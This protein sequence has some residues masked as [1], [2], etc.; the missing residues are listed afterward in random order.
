MKLVLPFFLSLIWIF[1]QCQDIQHKAISVGS[2]TNVSIINFTFRIAEIPYIEINKTKSSWG[3]GPVFQFG[4]NSGISKLFTPRLTGLMLSYRY[5]PNQASKRFAFHFSNDIFIQRIG[6]YW[7]ANAYDIDQNRYATFRYRN[8]EYLL[9]HFMGY[10]F[11][12]K[13]GNHFSL[14]KG[15]GLGYY[16]SKLQGEELEESGPEIENIDYRGYKN[17][18]FNWQIK[19]GI[20]YQI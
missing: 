15:I 9:Q 14:T 17:F 18:G 4:S 5:N 2:A 16:L 3:A 10:G 11:Q 6:D 7:D 19:I 1:G 20:C 13:I 12:M 8:L